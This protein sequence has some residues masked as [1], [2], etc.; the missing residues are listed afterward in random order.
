MPDAGTSIQASEAAAGATT[1][2]PGAIKTIV[3]NFTVGR[4]MVNP[5]AQKI[6]IGSKGRR[7]LQSGVLLPLLGSISAQVATDAD[8]ESIDRGMA[9][10][11]SIFGIGS[12][13]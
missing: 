2:E 4:I 5:V 10:L 9:G 7:R 6:F 11:A 1:L 12:E 3:K 13:P 8:G